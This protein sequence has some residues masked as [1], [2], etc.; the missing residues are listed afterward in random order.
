[1][2]S[3]IKPREYGKLLPQPEEWQLL[4][5]VQLLP[6]GLAPASVLPLGG[7]LAP[8]SDYRTSVDGNLNK[9]S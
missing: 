8:A 7:C 4:C 9:T 5:L 3:L 6:M 2:G 1:M